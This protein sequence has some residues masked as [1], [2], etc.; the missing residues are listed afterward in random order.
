MSNLDLSAVADEAP[1]V[2]TDPNAGCQKLTVLY[3]PATQTVQAF[4]FKGS[5]DEH[6]EFISWQFVMAVL[7]MAKVAAKELLDNQRMAAMAQMQQEAIM[8][9]QAA[10]QEAQRIERGRKNGHRG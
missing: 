8:K 3:N 2:V 9:Q 5:T 6:P 4:D 7:D 1:A 10:F